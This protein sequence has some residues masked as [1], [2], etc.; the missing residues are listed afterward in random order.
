MT[1]MA[2]RAVTA[3]CGLVLAAVGLSAWVAAPPRGASGPKPEITAY[4]SPACG[5]CGGWV[6]HM[7]ENG[8]AVTVVDVEN[9]TLKRVELGVPMEL[10]SCHTSVAEG[11]VLEGH[12]PADA[13]HRLLRERP[14]AHGLA[15]AGMPRGSPGM[16]GP[17]ERYPVHLLHRDAPAEVYLWK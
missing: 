1:R 6:D 3:A 5:C 13:V 16:P 8:F 14:A 15:V 7:R 2:R 9:P 17:A 10:S 12:V 4:R 11:Y